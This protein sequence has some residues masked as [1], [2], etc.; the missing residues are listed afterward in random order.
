MAFLDVHVLGGGAT[1]GV[2]L[3]G[4][5]EEKV[6]EC[7]RPFIERQHPE[8]PVILPGCILQLSHVPCKITDHHMLGKPQSR[9]FMWA[10]TACDSFTQQLM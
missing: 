3:C 2:G 7:Q 9:K 10:Y 6:C 8:P 1:A 4:G 5:V